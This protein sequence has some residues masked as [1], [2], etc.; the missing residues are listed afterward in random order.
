LLGIV[1]NGDAMSEFA[2][3]GR[4]STADQQAVGRRRPA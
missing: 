4:V 2:F 1:W 3:C